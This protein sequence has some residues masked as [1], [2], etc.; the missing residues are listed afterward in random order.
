MRVYDLIGVGNSGSG[1]R[2]Q[3]GGFLLLIAGY[4][5]RKERGESKKGLAQGAHSLPGPLGLQRDKEVRAEEKGSC[6]QEEPS[7]T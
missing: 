4:P 3:E 5:K 7:E 2:K 6:C 1:L